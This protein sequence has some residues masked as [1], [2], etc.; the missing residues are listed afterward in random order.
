M[1]VTVISAVEF[2]FVYDENTLFFLSLTSEL[3][4]MMMIHASSTVNPFFQLEI[5]T[6]YLLCMFKLEKQKKQLNQWV[7]FSHV[8]ISFFLWQT[9]QLTTKILE[10]C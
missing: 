10:L 3:I 8:I 7:Q 9:S 1:D 6:I 5:L 4:L 2:S